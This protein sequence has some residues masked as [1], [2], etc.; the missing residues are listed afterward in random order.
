MHQKAAGV[1]VEFWDA[2]QKLSA[3]NL[4]GKTQYTE[5]GIPPGM[6]K[7]YQRIDLQ[8]VLNWGG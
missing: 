3:T 1:G 4:A 8:G 5:F 6:K 7:P 2:E